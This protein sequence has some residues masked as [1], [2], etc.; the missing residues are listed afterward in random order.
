VGA[1]RSAAAAL[2]GALALA[3][4]CGSERTFSAEEFVA[5]ANAN[6][7]GLSL[8]NPLETAR[9]EGIEL[10]TV[11][12]AQAEGEPEDAGEAAHGHAGGTLTITPDP[13]AGA[14]E[15]ERCEQAASLICFRAA[16][17]VLLFEDALEPEDQARIAGALR[18]MAGE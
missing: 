8:G 11:E 5:E 18:G 9:K 14:A 2:L 16:N 10:H 13:S 4:G 6:G 17:A 15:F 7:A 1:P 12:L 3:A